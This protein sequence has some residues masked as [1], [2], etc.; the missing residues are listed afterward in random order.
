[1]TTQRTQPPDG[2]S[3]AGTTESECPGTK[4][5]RE[6][7]GLL[8]LSFGALGGLGALGALHWTAG[9]SAALVGLC[10]GGVL[11]RRSAQRR[12]Q[13]DSGAIAAFCGYAGQTAVLFHLAPPLGW[14]AV[15]V[16]A[17][18]VGFWLSSAEGA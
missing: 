11:A 16:L 12:W 17:V 8:L 6:A 7:L 3:A 13:Q 9:L 18:A 10:V 14:L 4:I 5:G 2:D 15:S 1:M